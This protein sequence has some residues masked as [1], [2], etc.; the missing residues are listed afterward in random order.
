MD[1]ELRPIEV[2]FQ[3]G[4][5]AIVTRGLNVGDRVVV[6]GGALLDG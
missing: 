2:D 3:Q 5:Q 4:D 6:M 1:F